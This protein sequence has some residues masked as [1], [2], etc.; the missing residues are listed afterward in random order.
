MACK[1]V[2][3]KNWGCQILAN[4]GVGKVSQSQS[5]KS[6][7][8]KELVLACGIDLRLIICCCQTMVVKGQN[9]FLRWLKHEI[10]ANELMPKE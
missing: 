1:L 9:E 5:A 7:M 2:K 4:L 6:M 8:R 10:T 3:V